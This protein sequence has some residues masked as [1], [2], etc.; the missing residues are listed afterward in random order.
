MTKDKQSS[1]DKRV[2]RSRARDVAEREFSSLIDKWLNECAPFPF[3]VARVTHLTAAHKPSSL[4]VTSV[5]SGSVTTLDLIHNFSSK[6][7]H[8]NVKCD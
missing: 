6:I 1:E 7:P 4:P 3:C 5:T 8:E 2:A